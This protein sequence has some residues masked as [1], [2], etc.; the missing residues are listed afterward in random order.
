MIIVGKENPDVQLLIDIIY[1]WLYM[2]VLMGNIFVFKFMTRV[3]IPTEKYRT[4]NS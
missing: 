3:S 2:D 4:V 1:S